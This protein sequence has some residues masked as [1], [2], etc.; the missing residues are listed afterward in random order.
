[1]KTACQEENKFIVFWLVTNFPDLKIAEEC[2]EFVEQ[3]LEENEI[4]IKPASKTII[5]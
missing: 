5:M 2:K 3:V 4:M 1:L